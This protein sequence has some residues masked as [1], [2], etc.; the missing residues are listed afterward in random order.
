MDAT[1]GTAKAVN[2]NN[3]AITN[4]IAMPRGVCW[5]IK[6]VRPRPHATFG[7][8]KSIVLPIITSPIPVIYKTV[9]PCFC[10]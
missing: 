3:T 6:L 10:G 9:G 5:K 1:N 2:P 7:L 8:S 4:K